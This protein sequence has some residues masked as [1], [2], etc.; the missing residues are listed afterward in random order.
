M[1]QVMI[2]NWS[3]HFFLD[4]AIIKP[5]TDIGKVT[6]LILNFNNVE[7]VIERQ[8][9]ISAKRYPPFPIL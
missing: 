7:H 5:M 4:G 9:L 2:D 3:E 1:I 8:A 6:A